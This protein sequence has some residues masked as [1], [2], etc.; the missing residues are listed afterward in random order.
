MFSL[1]SFVNKHLLALP[2]FFFFFFGNMLLFSVV[3]NVLFGVVPLCSVSHC[4]M[5]CFEVSLQS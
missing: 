3:L 4:S 1:K 2:L 5:N